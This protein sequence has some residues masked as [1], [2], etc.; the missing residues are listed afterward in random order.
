MALPLPDDAAA[1]AAR[2]RLTSIDVGVSAPTAVGL[3]M[4]A[5]AVVFVAGVQGNAYPRPLL[6]TRVVLLAGSHAGGVV[7]GPTPD[8]RNGVPLQHM[9]INA[10]AGIVTLE[11]QPASAAI[12]L[13]DA[14]TPE[15]MDA[16][17][18]AGWAEAERA[19]DEGIELI[20]VA[21]GGPGA[22]TAA[23][24]VIAAITGADPPGL[25][26]RVVTPAGRY[27]D[28]AWMTRCLALRDALHRVRDRHGD[29]RTVLAALGGA[30]IAAATGLLLGASSRRTPVMIDGPVGA[31]AALLANDMAPQTR[32]WIMMP[33]TARHPAVRLAAG[34]LELRPWLDL[35]LDLGE[36]CSSLTALPLLQNALTLAGVG[37]P[38]DDVS[39][40]RYDSSGNQVFVG[41]AKPVEPPPVE[42]P[43]VATVGAKTPVKAAKADA[44]AKAAEPAKADAPAKADGAERPRP[45]RPMRP[46]GP[47][48]RTRRRPPPRSPPSRPRPPM[49]AAMAAAKAG[50]RPTAA[51]TEAA[52]TAEPA[53][54]TPPAAK[55]AEPAAAKAGKPAEPAGKAAKAGPPPPSKVGA[56]R[57]PDL[58]EDHTVP[59]KIARP[60]AKAVPA[61]ATPP[62]KDAAAK[63]AAG[64]DTQAKDTAAAKD[65][66]RRT[67]RPRRTGRPGRRPTPTG[68]RPR[69]HPGPPP[70]T[71]PPRTPPR[72]PPRSA[73]KDS[74]AKDTV[75]A[76]KAPPGPATTTE[77]N[78]NGGRSVDTVTAGSSPAPAGPPRPRKRP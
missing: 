7:A 56:S 65:T 77:S 61:K 48:R 54:A 27:D 22:A 26:P 28:N 46:R 9:A 18:R 64:K 16:A 8:P 20:I 67:R 21:A 43:E 45:P 25:L 53:K 76:G 23:V 38:V 37:E 70:R 58:T 6:S 30:D 78:P 32:R 3:G 66:R 11:W 51:K 75:A 71:P 52:K 57:A 39:L 1:M 74:T 35:C 17:L 4:L 63:G 36:G 49:A 15:Q 33:D 42:E 73:A 69:R 14:I 40:T 31:A 59:I 47:P 10:G 68:R 62:A 60:P 34:A 2:E 72:S 29:A 55:A 44:P 12:E 50:R 41:V 5:E 24:A 19:A 13:E